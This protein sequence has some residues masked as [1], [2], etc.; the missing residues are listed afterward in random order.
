MHDAQ[1]TITCDRAPRPDDVERVRAGLMA[2]NESEVGPAAISRIAFYLRDD[3]GTIRGGLVGFLAWR[4]LSIDLLWVDESLR[5]RG[6][7]TAL[8]AQAE[9]L[10]RIDGCVGAR[11][12]TYDFQA[13]P[14]YEQ[15]GYVVF[16]ILDGY[17]AGGRTYYLKK[18]L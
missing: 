13:R 16:G 12:D 1:L 8:L 7:G 11:L 3:E 4:W 2:F 5:K 14:F 10:A 15:R 17:P 18:V 6:F 9:Q